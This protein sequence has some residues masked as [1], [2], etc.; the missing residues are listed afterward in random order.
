MYFNLESW[1]RINKKFD[2]AIFFR[3]LLDLKTCEVIISYIV[4]SKR[5]AP[6]P[7]WQSRTPPTK[8]GP[9][10]KLCVTERKKGRCSNWSIVQS[11]R[12][13]CGW[14]KEAQSALSATWHR[15]WR[16]PRASSDCYNLPW[17][18]P[19]LHPPTATSTVSRSLA[20]HEKLVDAGHLGCSAVWTCRRMDTN[21]RSA[22]SPP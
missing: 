20:F 15:S 16:L 7:W 14:H 18:R 9:A 4:M 5:R 12:L 11:P 17:P 19:K 10:S 6:G 8:D 3:K 13:P 2:P 22:R 1:R 21:V